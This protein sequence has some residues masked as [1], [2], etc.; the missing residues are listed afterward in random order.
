MGLPNRLVPGNPNNIPPLYQGVRR[1]SDLM[2]MAG[3]TV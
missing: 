3:E 1:I 2:K